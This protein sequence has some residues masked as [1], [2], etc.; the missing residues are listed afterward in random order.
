MKYQIQT[1]AE[2]VLNGE[3]LIRQNGGTIYTNDTFVIS[4]V[5][6]KYHFENNVLT[7]VI[8]DKPWLASWDM[9]EEKIKQFF[10]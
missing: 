5:S 3:E 7:I 9:I 4:G 10:G 1:T 2:K 8:T 6:G